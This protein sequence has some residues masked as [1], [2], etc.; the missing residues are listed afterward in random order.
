MISTG[1][2]ERRAKTS[3]AVHWMAVS[4]GDWETRA[5]EGQESI[6][7]SG[8]CESR[9]GTGADADVLKAASAAAHR[10]EPPVVQLQLVV[11]P[12][13]LVRI[14]VSPS[15]TATAKLRSSNSSC[16]AGVTVS[17]VAD[18]VPVLKEK[19]AATNT[20]AAVSAAVLPVLGV[21]LLPVLVA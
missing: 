2:C 11:V 8:A 13:A 16:H 7:S 18:A 6:S 15:P 9:T 4:T 21:V 5:G 1:A 3:G 17:T 10:L 20:S 19:A 14:R 12:L